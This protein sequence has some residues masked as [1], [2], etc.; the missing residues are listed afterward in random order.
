MRT[1]STCTGAQRKPCVPVDQPN[2]RWIVERLDVPARDLKE[3]GI[4]ERLEVT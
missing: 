4:V 1:C 2:Y 3:V